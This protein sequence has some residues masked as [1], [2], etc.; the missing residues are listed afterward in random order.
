M[1]KLKEAFKE[2]IAASKDIFADSKDD[3]K[4]KDNG[5]STQP[6]FSTDKKTPIV[7]YNSHV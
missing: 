7:Y 2:Y 1:E 6:C 4:E 3:F 5:N